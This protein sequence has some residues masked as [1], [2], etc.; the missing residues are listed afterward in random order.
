MRIAQINEVPNRSTGSLMKLISGYGW[1]KGEEIYDFVPCPNENPPVVPGQYYIGT[2]RTRQLYKAFAEKTGLNGFFAYF[3]TQKMLRQF[4]KLDIQLIHLHNIHNYCLHMP[5]L[6][7][8]VRKHNIPIIWSLHGCWAFTAK[9]THFTMAECDRWKTGCHDCPQLDKWPV[10]KVDRTRF[11]WNWKKKC[12]ASLPKLVTVGSSE[13]I[14]D[15]ARQS[16][17]GVHD[18][19]TI[20][21]GINLDVFKPTESRFRERIGCEDKIILLGVADGWGRNKG[22]HS[23]IELAKKLEKD[24]RYRIVLVGADG[25]V[26]GLLQK[27]SVTNV[28]SVEKITDKAKLAKVYSAADVFLQTTEE[29]T[30]GLVN[31]EALAC[32]TPVITFNTGGS[33]EAVDET[34]GRVVDRYDV[35]GMLAAIEEQVSTHAMTREACVRRAQYFSVERMC[36]D[37]LALYRE[38]I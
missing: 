13:W 37:Y 12:Y 34:C 25:Y 30:F 6:F 26:N 38:L 27:N 9:C 3:A 32:G 15:L 36:E 14:S 2:I 35:D 20:N 1:S 19:R 21:Y 24:D 23:M 10:S 7:R 16:I 17:L 29:E 22:I 8:Y 18:V 28:I 31:V 11:V 33:P 5:S 4:T